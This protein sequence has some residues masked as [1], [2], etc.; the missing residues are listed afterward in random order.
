MNAENKIVLLGTG[1]STGVPVLTCD[2]KVCRSNDSRD[3]RLRTSAYVEYDGLKLI[4]DCGPDFRQQILK[5]KIDDFDAI[6]I[7]HGH[8]DH[9]A[10]L[11]EVR[12]FNYLK[13]KTV[14]IYSNKET[15][16]AVK[17]EFPYIFDPGEYDGPPLINFH[18][19]DKEPFVIKN[20][21]IYPVPVMHANMN[22][23][24]FKIGELAY[25]TDASYI[26]DD[27]IEK[28]LESKL[29][30]INALRKK[31]HPSHITLDEALDYIKRINPKKACL[32]HISHFLGF[33]D[34]V[35]ASLP[36]NVILGYDGL[37]INI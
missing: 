29:L 36:Q 1:T 2:C 12:A 7:T 32:T 11:D 23:L 16:D 9:I 15:I 3:Q 17:V 20:Q 37:I 13:G 27:S 31:K 5:N 30:V 8:R 10:G 22:I 24:G 26:P 28:V 34:D 25:I 14:D 6:L 33:Y 21:K 18:I 19:I 4:I 35:Q